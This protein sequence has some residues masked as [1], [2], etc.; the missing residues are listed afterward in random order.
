MSDQ[1][2]LNVIGCASSVITA[3][4]WTT[5]IGMAHLHGFIRIEFS[6]SFVVARAPH[7]YLPW[8]VP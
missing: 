1:E 3:L 7:L 8:K 5:T 6:T 2:L 4:Y